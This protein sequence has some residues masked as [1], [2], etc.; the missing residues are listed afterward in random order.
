MARWL[1]P[2]PG[3]GAARTMCF[4]FD[5]VYLKKIKGTNYFGRM[6]PACCSGAVAIGQVPRDGWNWLA[7]VN[8]RGRA[9]GSV[10]L[11]RGTPCPPPNLKRGPPLRPLMLRA[12]SI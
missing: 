6:S 7:V 8:G 1:P 3:P 4:G 9:Q 10:T 2:C 12:L 11:L 5:S